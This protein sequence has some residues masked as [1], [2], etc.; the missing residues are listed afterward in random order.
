[1]ADIYLAG[2]CFWGQEKY[3]F[4]SLIKQEPLSSSIPQIPAIRHLFI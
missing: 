1:M 4:I 2:G 3:I